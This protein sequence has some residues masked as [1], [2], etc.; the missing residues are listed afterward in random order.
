RAYSSGGV[1]A[2][3]GM[4]FGPTTA[5]G[6]DRIQVID[7][8]S[9]RW[10]LAPSGVATY[11]GMPPVA[12][13]KPFRDLGVLRHDP[14]GDPAGVTINPAG[15]SVTDIVVPTVNKIVSLPAD[16]APLLHAVEWHPRPHYQWFLRSG[17][18]GDP[19]YMPFNNSGDTL[20]VNGSSTSFPMYAFWW[21]GVP[22]TGIADDEPI[23]NYWRS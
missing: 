19:Y 9:R 11:L 22:L 3:W 7:Q 6:P 15:Y 5:S 13:V 17:G 8:C 21:S 18:S 10:E 1:V 4:T 12:R 2:T 23:D 14:V 20:L 16:W